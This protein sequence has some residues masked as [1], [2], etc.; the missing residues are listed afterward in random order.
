MKKSQARLKAEYMAEAGELFDEL[1][2]WD[3]STP[4]PDLSQI[5]EVV[6]ALRKRIGERM[7][8]AVLA[9]QERGQPS[10]KILCPECEKEMEDKGQKESDVE[11]QVGNLKIERSYYY[12]PRCQR[13]L[14]P[15][16]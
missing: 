12:C 6:L 3:E 13:G 15:L 5:E 11:T 8:E 7:A 14:F 9:R 10:E 4:E 2:A 16:R 1:M